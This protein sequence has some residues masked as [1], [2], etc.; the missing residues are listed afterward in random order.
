MLVKNNALVMRV[1]D[2]APIL[3]ALPQAKLVMFGTNEL[4]VVKHTL[5][6]ARVLNNLGLN[7][8]SPILHGHYDFPGRYTPME[9]QLLTASFLTLNSRAYC[10]NQM[11]TGKTAAALWASEFLV[12]EGKIKRILIVSPVDVMP[13]WESEGFSTVTHRDFTRLVGS[14]DK[15]IK[16]ANEPTTYSVINFDGLRSL[17][18]EEYYG[19]TKRVKKRW[20]DLEGMYDLIIVDEAEA[21]CNATNWRWKALNCLVKP[22]TWLWMLTG[23]PTPNAPTDAYGLVKLMH[24]HKVPASFKLFEEQ[25]M[26]P[27]GPYK[28]V[29]REGAVEAVQALMQPAI[30]FMR[31]ECADLPTTTSNRQCDMTAEQKRVF[32]DLKAKMRHEDEETE[33]TAVNAAVKLVKLQQVMCGVVKDDDGNAVE[34][35][36]KHRL[37]AVEHLV[38]GG[39]AKAVIFVPFKASMYMISNYLASKGITNEVINGDIS[40]TKRIEIVGRFRN[41]IDPHVLIAHPKVAAHGQDFT[42]ADTF[43]WYGPTFS[44]GQYEQACARGEGAKKTRPVGI[45]HIGCHPVEWK[46]YEATAAKMHGQSGLLD[47]YHSVFD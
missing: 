23:T 32:D 4:V 10:F 45:Y 17:Y 24:P 9:K 18:H 27:V 37:E 33:I 16:L 31:D 1:N 12:K 2:P 22:E 47:M 29:P 42:V 19:N 34:L 44:S 15:R 13:V 20:H 7:A 8:P 21:Y 5:D 28:K 46:I 14:A 11:R 6:V 40:K 30:R 3:D 39:E 25:M 43:I 26:R 41:S 38:R 35:N 36:P